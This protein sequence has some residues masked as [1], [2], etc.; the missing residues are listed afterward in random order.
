MAGALAA[1]VVVFLPVYFFVIIPGRTLRRHSEHPRLAGFIRGVTAAARPIAGAAIAGAA[2]A[3]AAI[4]IGEE[5]IT[6]AGSV[7]VALVALAVLLQRRVKC[8]SQRS[9]LQRPS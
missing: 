2:I 7:I 4:V 3:G 9:W 8:P 5:V 6:S 1:T